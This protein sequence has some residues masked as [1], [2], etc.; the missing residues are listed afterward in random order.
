VTVQAAALTGEGSS[1]VPDPLLREVTPLST[2]LETRPKAEVTFDT[3]ANGIL[4]VF[5]QDKY[6]GKSN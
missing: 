2:M 4:N 1:Q 3:G 5:A 6:T